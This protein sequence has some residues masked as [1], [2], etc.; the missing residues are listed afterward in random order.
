MTN[1]RS[2][3]SKIL[4][5]CYRHGCKGEWLSQ[6]I[7]FHPT[8]KTLEAKQV[9]DRT[10][11][12][13]D[14]F[15]K[16]FLNSWFP[17][18]EDMNK[19]NKDNIVVPSHHFYDYLKD[20]FPDADY[21]SIDLPEDIDTYRQSLFERYYLYK[22]DD[23]LELLGECKNSIR[24]HRPGISLEEEKKFA[25]EVLRA[26]VTDFGDIHCMAKGVEPTLEN[27]FALLDA[28]ESYLD[29][30]SDDTRNNSLVIKF[31]DVKKIDI[32]TIV[33]HFNK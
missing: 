5:V 9:N 30:L 13:N 21:V 1:W 3:V 28:Q 7:S 8:Y 25:S 32:N 15:G 6:Q 19:P 27:K 11:I 31:E 29:P 20:Y 2:L 10:V 22:T 18:Y 23:L 33:D 24:I 14:H 12:T 4:F 26:K 17:S 16:T